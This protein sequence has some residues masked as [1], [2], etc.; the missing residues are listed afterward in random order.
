MTSPV[1]LLYPPLPPFPITTDLY[2]KYDAILREN[3]YGQ[4]QT[5]GDWLK[6]HREE[7]EKQLN[8]FQKLERLRARAVADRVSRKYLVGQCD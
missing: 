6:Q 1:L 2:W 7:S 3:N 5:W 4:T 8:K